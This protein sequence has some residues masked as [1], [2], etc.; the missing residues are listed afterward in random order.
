MKELG[1]LF[2][3]AGLL[4]WLTLESVV[5]HRLILKTL[6]V[7]LRASL[8]LHLAPPAVACVAYL[9]VTDGPPDRLAQILFGYALFQALVTLRLVPWLRRQPF[10]PAAWAYTF[11]VSALP[12][13]AL[14]LT[15]RGLA[16]PSAALAVPLFVAANLVIG[17]IAVRTLALLLG[18]RR[19][20]AG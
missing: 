7:G 9:A 3:G 1:L 19:A 8:G 4:S 10:S 12:L 6:P 17:W 18:S 16:G 20:P 11:G 14:R 2:F 15:E 13:A 5:V